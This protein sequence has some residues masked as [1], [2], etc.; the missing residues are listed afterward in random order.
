MFGDKTL[1]EIKKITQEFFQK[2]GFGAKVSAE[3]KENEKISVKITTEDPKILIGQGGETLMEIQRLIR[4]MARRK[5]EDNFYFDLDINGYKEKKEDYLK[6]TARS[7]AN[8]A[9][10]DQ[11]EKIMPSMSSYERRVVHLELAE[12]SDV[13][14]ESRGEERERRVVIKPLG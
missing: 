7:L 9:A 8:E 12:R 2:A 4:A 6:E 3:R 14:T 11:E 5:L 1:K 13:T 10:L